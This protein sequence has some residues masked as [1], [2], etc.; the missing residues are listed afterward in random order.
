[1][2]LI[3]ILSNANGLLVA[4]QQPQTVG[5]LVALLVIGMLGLALYFIRRH[6][7]TMLVLPADALVIALSLWRFGQGDTYRVTVDQQHHQ[8]VSQRID[9][10]KVVANTTT[11]A[12][13]LTSAEMQFN[14]GASKI[15]L[16]HRDG[17]Q[18]FP[19][20]EQE[21]QDEPNQYVVLNAMRLA[22]GQSPKR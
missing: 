12:S 13:D 11:P 15:V 6:A 16:I 1:M 17:H 8:I 4:E 19:L 5:F 10:N 3:S 21:L 9:G 7:W 20:G 14:R 22:I 2:K 18:S